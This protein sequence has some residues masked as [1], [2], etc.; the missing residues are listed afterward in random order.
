MFAKLGVTASVSN[1]QELQEGLHNFMDGVDRELSDIK[2]LDGM[3][4]FL[5]C[6]EIGPCEA[7]ENPKGPTNTNWH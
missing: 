4:S 5:E 7:H 1:K 6:T 2:L 3:F